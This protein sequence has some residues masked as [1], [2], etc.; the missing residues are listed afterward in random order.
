M[1]LTDDLHREAQSRLLRPEEPT[2]RA[3]YVRVKTGE[4]LAELRSPSA[5]FRE[6]RKPA[7]P[8]AGG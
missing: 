8:K 2:L 3:Q 4:L 1:T 6:R 7:D 5:D